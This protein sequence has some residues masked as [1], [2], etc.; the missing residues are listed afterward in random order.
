MFVVELASFSD[1]PDWDIFM[2][3]EVNF[4]VIAVPRILQKMMMKTKVRRAFWM[5]WT[6]TSVTRTAVTIASFSISS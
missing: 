3:P 6:T 1:A 4:Y 2:G 5:S